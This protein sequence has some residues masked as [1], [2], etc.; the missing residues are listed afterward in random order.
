MGETDFHSGYRKFHED[1]K[2]T[3]DIHGSWHN[4]SFSI[5]VDVPAPKRI[6]STEVHFFAVI[7]LH[8]VLHRLLLID[9]CVL[10]VLISK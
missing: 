7:R 3:A 1:E 6:V 10:Y 5:Y 2:I 4:I 8:V 9:C